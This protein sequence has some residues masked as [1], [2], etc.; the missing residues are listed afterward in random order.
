LGDARVLAAVNGGR[1]AQRFVI[2]LGWPVSEARII[3]PTRSDEPQQGGI[4]LSIEA[5]GRLTLDV[6]G[7]TGVLAV[8]APA[9]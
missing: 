5:G 7:L 9:P 6:E 1:D 3:E 8:P 4:P 2:T